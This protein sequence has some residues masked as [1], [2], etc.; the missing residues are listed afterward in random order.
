MEPSDDQRSRKDEAGAHLSGARGFREVCWVRHGESV[1]NIGARTE[2]SSGYTLTAYGEKQ[3]ALFAERLPNPPD[4]IVV[5]RYRRAQQ[6]AAP[7]IARFAAVPVEEW[8]VEEMHYLS[9]ERTRQTTQIE[10]RALGRGFW[11][12]SDP[13]FVEGEGA[14]SFREF[15]ARADDALLRSRGAGHS[16]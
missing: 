3:A 10:R 9:S 16:S 2:D 15:I 14:E 11:D 7:C 13:D 8:P 4:L 1:G 12:L 6:T 5:S